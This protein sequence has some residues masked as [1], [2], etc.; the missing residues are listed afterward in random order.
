M[1]DNPYQSPV[2]TAVPTSEHRIPQLPKTVFRVLVVG[3][4]V[5]GVL[6]ILVYS[7]TQFTL[8]E[9]LRAY[10]EMDSQTAVTARELIL[11]AL[12]ALLLVLILISSIGL[13][14]FWRPARTLFAFTVIFG[15]LITPFFGPH[16]NTGWDTPLEEAASIITGI[17]LA[18]AYYS[19]LSVLFERP[20]QIA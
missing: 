7:F 19:P 13:I 14:L 15:L 4:I 18:L 9:P 2:L 6:S 17:I 11:V 5:L 10:E 8:P 12:A 3:E 16:V 20:Q 1:D